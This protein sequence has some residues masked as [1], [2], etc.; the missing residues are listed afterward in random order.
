MRIVVCIKTVAKQSFQCTQTVSL[1]REEKDLEINPVDRA[2]LNMAVNLKREFP[3]SELTVLCMG[4]MQSKYELLPLYSLGADNIYLLNDPVFAGSD[5]LATS[6]ILSEAINQKMGDW[7]YV[8]C[9]RQSADGGTEQ[10]SARLSQLLNAVLICGVDKVQIDKNGK[11]VCQRKTDYQVEQVETNERTVI[12]CGHVKEIMRTPTIREMLDA[13]TKKVNILHADDLKLDIEK[14]GLKGSATQVTNV[15]N[16]RI[17]RN[18]IFVK[19]N[20]SGIQFIVDRIS[21]FE[22]K[23]GNA[24]VT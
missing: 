12:A 1:Q 16:L 7:D 24:I 10:V 11:L 15:L 23:G 9:G 22:C 4:I 19:G 8:F 6:Y 21:S 17:E 14:C 18:P 3:S 20:K 13:A 5:T 2:A